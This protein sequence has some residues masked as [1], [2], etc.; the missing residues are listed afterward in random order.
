MGISNI[1]MFH[2]MQIS[3]TET[4]SY[5]SAKLN[6]SSDDD[7]SQCQELGIREHV[8]YARCPLYIPGIDHSEDNCNK[9]IQCL[10]VTS[11]ISLMISLL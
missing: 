10:V 1:I 5:T 11:K 6:Y 3:A 9:I 7:E 8:L 2:K 4:K